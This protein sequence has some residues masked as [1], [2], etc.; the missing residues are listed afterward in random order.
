[1]QRIPDPTLPQLTS[2]V[3]PDIVGVSAPFA[4]AS[5]RAQPHPEMLV[6]APTTGTMLHSLA[7]GATL[8]LVTGVGPGRAEDRLSGAS[9]CRVAGAEAEAR[10]GLPPGLLAAIGRVESGRADP[11]TGVVAIWPWTINANGAGQMFAS[12]TAAVAE[13][14][15]LRASGVSSIDVGCFQINLLHHPAAFSSVE[16]AFDPRTNADYAARFLFALHERLGGW[17]R[18]SRPITHPHLKGVYRIAAEC[19]RV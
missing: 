12:A 15:A 19:S 18:R 5:L 2:V 7:L 10:F 1:L 13:T 17:S 4:L 6:R 9:L 14:E 3:V 11:A 16:Q 8:F